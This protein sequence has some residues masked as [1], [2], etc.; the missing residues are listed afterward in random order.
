M[1]RRNCLQIARYGGIAL[2]AATVLTACVG[3]AV[4]SQTDA[5]SELA[6]TPSSSS[7]AMPTPTPTRASTPAR[8]KPKPKPSS[9]PSSTVPA[10]NTRPVYYPPPST[11]SPIPHAVRTTPNPAPPPAPPPA[12]VSSQ[13]G[14]AQAVLNA[15]NAARAKAGVPALHWLGGL[16]ASAHQHNLAMAA[17]NSLAHQ[18]PGEAGLGSRISAQGVSW[19]Y[20]A[21][22]IGWTTDR[23][24]GGALSIEYSME[25]EKAPNDGHRQNIRS[26]N[27]KYIGIDVII[28]NAHGKLWLTEDF[29]G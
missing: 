25:A 2:A 13:S 16:Q 11:P 10:S 15:V 6:T 18:L 9:K 19:S 17:A 8:P 29:S 12:S 27:L 28:D 4:R 24:T 7:A 3:P 1:F 20:A 26:K 5:L 23:S 22:N 14:M 21:E